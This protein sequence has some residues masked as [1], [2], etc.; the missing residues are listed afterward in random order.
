[1]AYNLFPGLKQILDDK[2]I[3]RFGVPK[4]EYQNYLMAEQFVVDLRGCDDKSIKEMEN[5]FLDFREYGLTLPPCQRFVLH[6]IVPSYDKKS[7]CIASYFCYFNGDEGTFDPI[8]ENEKYYVNFKQQLLSHP[9]LSRYLGEACGIAYEYLIV[10]LSTL[11]V[12]KERHEIKK[13]QLPANNKP[14]KK[15]SGGYTIIRPPE[16]HEIKGGSHASPRPH[17][18]RGHIRKL[19]P[20]D[21]TRWIFVSPCFVNGEPEVVRKSYLVAA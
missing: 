14:H 5:S 9:S 8:F 18:R 16:A 13:S 6:S 4:E 2:R 20:E 11:G 12:I 17:F 21:K 10:M 3:R 1:M 15:G 7:S 19:H